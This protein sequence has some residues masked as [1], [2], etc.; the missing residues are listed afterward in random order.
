VS[1]YTSPV[2]NHQTP[3]AQSLAYDGIPDNLR[4]FP[5]KVITLF[6]VSVQSALYIVSSTTGAAS[7]AVTV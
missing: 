5:Q 7:V 1:Q 6:H 4:L 2:V 3:A